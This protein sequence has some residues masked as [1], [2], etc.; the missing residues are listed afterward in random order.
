VMGTRGRT[1]LTNLVL[2]SIKF[3][4][5]SVEGTSV[6]IVQVG[7]TG[8]GDAGPLTVSLIADGAHVDTRPIDSLKSGEFTTVRITGPR[9]RRLR[10]VADRGETVPETV[11]E[12][13]ELKAR[14]P[15][16]SARR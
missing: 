8:E 3:G 14:C 10:A 9:C 15:A 13:N 6:Y 16:L 7:N 12:D 1:G 5:G 4:R 11:E 2:G